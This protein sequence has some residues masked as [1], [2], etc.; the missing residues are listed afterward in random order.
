MKYIQTLLSDTLN[1]E[2]REIILVG[3]QREQ[4]KSSLY[5]QIEDSSG[6]TLLVKGKLS[7]AANPTV[8]AT[9]DM[10][11]FAKKSA[12]NSNGIYMLLSEE[13]YS[14]VLEVTGSAMIT[15]KSVE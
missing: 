10:A 9:V 2:Q 3:E 12:I 1:N 13:L 14:V 15:V 6:L 11:E 8:L 5:L 7:Q 4:V